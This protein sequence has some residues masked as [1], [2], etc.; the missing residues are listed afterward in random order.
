MNNKVLEMKQ[1]VKE[2]CESII[3]IGGEITN[4]ETKE[5]LSVEIHFKDH[6]CDAIGGFYKVSVVEFPKEK[7]V[8]SEIKFCPQC[9]NKVEKEHKFCPQ[10]GTQIK[11]KIVQVPKEVLLNKIGQI[12]GIDV[13]G[14]RI[15]IPRYQEEITE[16]LVKLGKK[17]GHTIEEELSLG[18]VTVL[19]CKD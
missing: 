15:M 9:G 8:Q 13:I 4:I 16:E 6:N 10:C 1:L 19:I 2:E 3:K 7:E 5:D 18:S 17:T 11:E 14:D 12:D